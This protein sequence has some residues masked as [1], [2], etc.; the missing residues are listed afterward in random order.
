[1]RTPAIPGP[2][3]VCGEYGFGVQLRK[4][5]GVKGV[6]MTIR[7]YV[8]NRKLS[9]AWPEFAGAP[10]LPNLIPRMLVVKFR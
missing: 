5:D 6:A 10:C 7:E 4:K 3:C 1:M 2:E 8:Q 9:I